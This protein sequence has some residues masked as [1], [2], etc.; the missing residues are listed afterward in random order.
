MGSVWVTPY[1][2]VVDH[3]SDATFP[4]VSYAVLCD[5]Y[6]VSGSAPAFDPFRDS[7]LV[8][9]ERYDPSLWRGGSGVEVR[10]G[11][12]EVER[13]TA[14]QQAVLTAMREAERRLLD[15]HGMEEVRESTSMRLLRGAP[16]LRGL[17]RRLRQTRRRSRRAFQRYLERIARAAG[18]YRPVWDEITARVREAQQRAREK[19][20][21][22]SAVASR[23]WW[24]YRVDHEAGVVH[25][26]HEDGS[27]LDTRGLSQELL[28]V[29]YETGISTVRWAPGTWEAVERDSGSAFVDWWRAFTSA[30]WTDPERIP[31]ARRTSSGGVGHAHTSF[32]GVDTSG[33][34]DT[35]G[36]T[37]SL[38]SIHF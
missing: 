31:R 19:W 23:P 35:G 33:F 11:P 9:K 17:W 28:K 38:P 2:Y 4:G 27:T 1:R 26:F 25:V 20:E 32:F 13:W 3:G 21:R 15:D 8:H 14:A 36:S 7:W 22:M 12:A 10:A 37:F 29:R 16:G 6:L 5:L 18:S 34:P 24:S 30:Y